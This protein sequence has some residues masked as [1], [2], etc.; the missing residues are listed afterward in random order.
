MYD[1]IQ[2]LSQNIFSHK[3][4]DYG[5]N[6]YMRVSMSTQTKDSQS[7]SAPAFTINIK[8]DSIHKTVSLTY[9]KLFDIYNRLKEVIQAAGQEYNSKPG[10][11]DTQLHYQTG[12]STYLTFEFLR[13]TVQN[14]PVVRIT[15]SHGN[16]DSSKIIMP[17]SPEFHSFISLIGDMV[18]NRKYLSNWLL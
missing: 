4:K 14:E 9:Q 17:F 5:T 1:D 10:S 18:G 3:D 15:I 8:N 12:K 13:G 2:W 16:S 6:G 7:F 11:P